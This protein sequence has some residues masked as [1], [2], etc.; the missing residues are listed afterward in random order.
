MTDKVGSA[1]QNGHSTYAHLVEGE[2]DLVGL[3]AY[4]LYKRD[5]LQYIAKHI[6]E[7][8]IPPTHEEVMVLCRVVSLDGQKAAYRTTAVQLLTEM[9][10][11]IVEDR[12]DEE[13][14][15]HSKEAHPFWRSV[16]EHV[17]AGLMAALILGAFG[18][19]LYSQK[20]GVRKIMQQMIDLP[21]S[22]PSSQNE[23]IPKAPQR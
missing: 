5:K 4:S 1:P 11:G 23:T 7:K 20:I 15:A 13:V 8:G 6:G 16:W 2:D 14:L 10:E 3:V 18:I 22:E 12:V 21:F 19:I 9:Y 17:V